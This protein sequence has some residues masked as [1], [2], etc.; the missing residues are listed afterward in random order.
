MPHHPLRLPLAG[1]MVSAL[2]ALPFSGLSFAAGYTATAPTVGTGSAS[3]PYQI[4]TPD[5]LIWM[6]Q[7]ASGTS[8]AYELTANID[9]AGYTGWTPITGFGG[10]FNGNEHMISDLTTNTPIDSSTTSLEE[11]GVFGDTTGSA[12]VE[13]VELN[14]WTMAS[15]T[16][17]SAAGLV[18][19]NNG[20]VTGNAVNASSLSA[21]AM[22]MGALVGDNLSTDPNNL[23]FN[24]VKQ[25]TITD[26]SAN[27]EALGGIVGYNFSSQGTNASFVTGSTIIAT[28]A[29]NANIGGIA[30][31]L[32]GNATSDTLTNDTLTGDASSQY[33][34]VGGVAGYTDKSLNDNAVTQLTIQ[35]GAYVGGVVG[36]L[37]GSSATVDNNQVTATVQ[38]NISDAVVGL[39]SGYLNGG[40]A[41]NTDQ[42]AGSIS[43]GNEANNADVGGIVGY[44]DGA[45]S[46]VSSDVAITATQANT[47]YI[48]GVAGYNQTPITNATAVGPIT[49]ATSVTQSSVGNLVGYNQANLTDVSATSQMILPPVST[50][51]SSS[52]GGLVGYQ[53][54]GAITDA[55]AVT[56]DHLA[57]I[58]NT[59]NIDD[60]V[61]AIAG[62]QGGTAQTV[63]WDTTTEPTVRAFPLGNASTGT[64]GLSTEA[65]TTQ[66]ISTLGLG[67]AWS[68]SLGGYTNNA[69]PTLTALPPLSLGSSPKLT[70]TASTP[71]VANSTTTTLT[72]VLDP[73]AGVPAADLPLVF[74][75]QSSNGTQNA[76]GWT[77]T[78]GTATVT[79]PGATTLMPTQTE[80]VTVADVGTTGLIVT[81]EP[82][83]STLTLT[84]QDTNTP[85]RVQV[86][87]TV[88]YQNPLLTLPTNPAL[89]ITLNGVT[90]AVQWTKS[91]NSTQ[92]AYI[93]TTT[94]AVYGGPNTIQGTYSDPSGLTT[95]SHDTITVSTTPQTPTGLSVTGLTDTNATLTWPAVTG[96]NAYTVQVNTNPVLTVYGTTTSVT[97]VP[98]SQSHV[99]VQAVYRTLASSPLTT[100]ITTP[101]PPVRTLTVTP[102]PAGS[103]TAT[104]T[105]SAVY[106]ATTYLIAMN[107]GGW[108]GFTAGPVTWHN[109]P[110]N[111]SLVTTIA[112]VYDNAVSTPTSVDTFIPAAPLSPITP[113]APKITAI[114]PSTAPVGT[115]V[116]I[117]GTGFGSSGTVAIQ[118][119]AVT[120]VVTPTLWSPTQI[121]LVLPT[122]N[123]GSAKIQLTAQDSQVTTTASLTVSASPTSTTPIST[124]N[125]PVTIAPTPPVPILPTPPVHT[126]TS[127]LPSSTSTRLVL[128]PH[129]IG[130]LEALLPNR[131]IITLS[132][133]HSVA[134]ATSIQVR[135][136]PGI[137]TT[138]PNVLAGYE[139]FQLSVTNPLDVH[140]RIT[141]LPPKDEFFIH[142]RTVLPKGTTI[143][144]WDVTRHRWVI[145]ARARTATRVMKATLPHM[146]TMTYVLVPPTHTS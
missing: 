109:L 138:L 20:Q 82:M 44:N 70:E 99:T 114:T 142:W 24:L 12:L 63:Y 72:G 37:S 141:W 67:S 132:V 76:I 116:T 98:A 96:A 133:M 83:P 84:A 11:L 65:L 127:T 6:D 118:Q 66:S 23:T 85:N 123:V 146:A 69:I 75:Q 94:L 115:A 28:A 16:S 52:F 124:P 68:N 119:G 48:G 106:G 50:I 143:Q 126:P 5:Q 112:A 78:N 93:A 43:L 113:P 35:G 32:E 130:S 59:Q 53:G 18:A 25:T 56:N 105:W 73:A 51:E 135:Y 64:I 80:T 26:T 117:T 125:P 128:A 9:M 137:P 90:Q 71:F 139:V 57:A 74:S 62:Y 79:A 27:T 97:L 40:A 61:G 45:V 129:R 31:T 86:T 89:G 21:A 34:N 42:A 102:G 91:D 100:T 110:Q 36:Y 103:G 17:V 95:S 131:S 55:I 1:L 121:V 33:N 60:L 104:D 41:L 136:L 87:A 14:D 54:S 38:T 29:T 15:S 108:T 144:R 81:P 10:T 120:T 122:L 92:S 140:Q 8:D 39:I 134:T 88:A 111:Q 19:V 7:H 30:G 4:S 47:D 13:H 46:N 22:Q 145:M 49:L 77:G 101:P 2:L 3:N 58:A 107:N